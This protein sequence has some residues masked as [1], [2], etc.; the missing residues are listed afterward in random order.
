MLG[1]VIICY[2]GCARVEHKTE[3]PS[4]VITFL[5]IAID[6]AAGELCLPNDIPERFQE[7]ISRW[8]DRKASTKKKIRALLW[9]CCYCGCVLGEHSS[10]HCFSYCTNLITMFITGRY[11]VEEVPSRVRTL[12]FHLATILATSIHRCI[13][14]LGLW[15]C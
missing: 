2:S 13:W 10:G 15:C 6:T 14:F 5:G 9:S 11:Y 8:S 7:L 4:S 1:E 12:L 3:G